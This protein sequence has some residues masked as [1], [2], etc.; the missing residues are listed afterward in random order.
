M[1]ATKITVSL[2]EQGPRHGADQ[3]AGV[4]C[5]RGQQ[6]S[7]PHPTNGCSPPTCH[8]SSSLKGSALSS[9]VLETLQL[10][11]GPRLGGWGWPGDP[12][13]QGSEIPH[14]WTLPGL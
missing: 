5:A 6:H 14:G 1:T 2:T 8:L 9:L 12:P 13:N 3:K 10:E 7:A 4:P 11:P